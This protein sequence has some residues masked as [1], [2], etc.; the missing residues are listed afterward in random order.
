M[1]VQ[2]DEPL[3]QAIVVG[4]ARDWELKLQRHSSAVDAATV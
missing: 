1:G 4:L 2:A 3:T